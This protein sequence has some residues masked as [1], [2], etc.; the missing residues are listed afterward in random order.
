MCRLRQTRKRGPARLDPIL[1]VPASSVHRVLIRRGLNRLAFLG[2]PTGQVIRRHERHQPGALIHVDVKKLGRIPDGGGHRV[3][4]R[5]AG[6]ARRGSMGFAWRQ[7]LA[8]LGATGKLTRAY[9]PQAIG[10]VER[11]HRTPHREWRC[12]RRMS[13]SGRPVGCEGAD[14]SS[15]TMAEL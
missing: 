1:G 10:K 14:W 12:G 7:A 9:R 11:F 13:R 4:G 3:L 5:R 15:V 6:R 8:D 2:R